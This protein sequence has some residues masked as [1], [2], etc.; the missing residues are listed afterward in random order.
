M[1]ILIH[2]HIHIERERRNAHVVSR[3]FPGGLGRGFLGTTN[4]AE[5]EVIRSPSREELGDGIGEA[6]G[7]V[8]GVVDAAAAALPLSLSLRPLRRSRCA[9]PMG[10]V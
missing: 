3:G 8:A 2:I 7:E 9:S 6:G 4:P 5:P 10:R 1:H